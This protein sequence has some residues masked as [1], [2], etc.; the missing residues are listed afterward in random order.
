[1]CVEWTNPHRWAEIEW[2][3][4]KLP[5]TAESERVRARSEHKL[6]FHQPMRGSWVAKMQKSNGMCL[7]R[8]YYEIQCIRAVVGKLVRVICVNSAAIFFFSTNI[9]ALVRRLFF[10]SV[11]TF[12]FAQHMHISHPLPFKRINFEWAAQRMSKPF[13][14]TVMEKKANEMEAKKKISLGHVFRIEIPKS[15]NRFKPPFRVTFGSRKCIYLCWG[16]C[17][18]RCVLN[19]HDR[20]IRATVKR[21]M[22]CHVKQ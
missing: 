5:R 17:K 18:H 22:R 9:F 10:H 1:M 14:C 16:E 11:L 13:E 20:Q 21:V 8:R 19:T 2:K 6:R 15:G 4:H 12:L 7:I 3:Q